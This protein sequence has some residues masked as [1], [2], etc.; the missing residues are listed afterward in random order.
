MT[1]VTQS[2]LTFGDGVDTTAAV[3]EIWR[4]LCEA[5]QHRCDGKA[6]PVRR[7]ATPVRRQRDTS[8]RLGDARRRHADT[9]VKTHGV[10]GV[11]DMGTKI[12]F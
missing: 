1:F 5:R 3:R 4:R 9:F 7:L 2:D 8:R 12:S 11:L 10:G 6:T